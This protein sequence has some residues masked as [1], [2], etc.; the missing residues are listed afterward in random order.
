MKKK[1]IVRTIGQGGTVVNK[2]VIVP[3]IRR[4]KI[5]VTKP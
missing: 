2:N 3:L 1:K 4:P 5:V